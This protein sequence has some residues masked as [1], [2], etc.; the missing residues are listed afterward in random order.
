LPRLITGRKKLLRGKKE[1]A[2]Q[3]T[4]YK[5]ATAAA[6]RELIKKTT[7]AKNKRVIPV[8]LAELQN[9]NF[10]FNDKTP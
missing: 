4:I 6:N 5:K 1:A 2:T 8:I 3:I 10:L 7:A 9:G